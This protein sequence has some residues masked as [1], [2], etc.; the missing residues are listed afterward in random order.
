MAWRFS[1]GK[2][3]LLRANQKIGG[4]H[5][6]RKPLAWRVSRKA[7]VLARESGLAASFAGFTGV[8]L[9]PFLPPGT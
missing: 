7:P 1:C 5:Y 9:L 2:I 6:P 4:L 3:V 8:Y